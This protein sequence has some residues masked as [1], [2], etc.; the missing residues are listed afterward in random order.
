MLHI[1]IIGLDENSSQET[2]AWAAA[3]RRIKAECF[4][5]QDVLIINRVGADDTKRRGA[6]VLKDLGFKTV[7]QKNNDFE[8][9][10]VE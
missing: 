5:G 9:F 8:V 6:S 2:R 1:A 3:L 7:L 4:P 10:A